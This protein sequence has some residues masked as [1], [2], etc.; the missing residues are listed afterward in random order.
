[1]VL[2]FKSTL[3]GPVKIAN[4]KVVISPGPARH[5]PVIKYA[6][7]WGWGAFGSIHFGRREKGSMWFRNTSISPLII[8]DEVL[9]FPIDIVCLSN[10]TYF[11]PKMAPNEI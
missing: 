4:K 8:N 9:R 6:G 2:Y 10:S 7:G 11:P 3:L 1:M 5:M